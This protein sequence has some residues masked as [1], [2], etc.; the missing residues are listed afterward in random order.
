[1]ISPAM[2]EILM[3]YYTRPGNYQPRGPVDPEEHKKFESEAHEEFVRDGIL[4]RTYVA[5]GPDPVYEMTDAGN[6]WCGMILE[7]PKPVLQWVD[8]RKL[9][10]PLD[11]E[12]IPS[13]RWPHVTVQWQPKE[14]PPPDNKA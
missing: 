6:A 12:L 2:L 10:Y 14:D 1:M 11:P 4:R 9:G 8:P 7:T 13:A 5:S 3:W